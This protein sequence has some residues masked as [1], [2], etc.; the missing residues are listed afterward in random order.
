[1]DAWVPADVV[2]ELR[3]ESAAK[4]LL[5]GS[6]FAPWLGLASAV[7]AVAAAWVLWAPGHLYS[8][9]M[10]WDLLFNLEGAWHLAHGHVP[11]LDFHDPLGRLGFWLTSLG[12][13]VVGVTPK[14]FLVGEFIVL[15][16][17]LAAAVPVAARRLAPAPAL[18]FT[19][20][21][22]LLIV[23]PANIGDAPNAY[24][25]A[26]SYNRWGWAALAILCVLLFIDPRHESEPRW[27]ELLLAAMLGVFLF[28]VKIT[29]AAA[30]LAAVIAAAIVVRRI[31]E[32]WRL[33]M[34]LV[35]VIALAAVLPVNHPY[36]RETWTYATAGYARVNLP[37]IV[38]LVVSDRAAYAL[39]GAAIGLLVWLWQAGRAPLQA[40]LSAVVLVGLGLLVLTQNAQEADIPLG[41]VI[42]LQAYSTLACTRATAIDR[43]ARLAPPSRLMTILIVIL[44][45]PV[46]SVGAAVKVFAGY[47]YSASAPDVMVAP[48]TSNLRGLAVPALDPEVP[49]ALARMGYPLLSTTRVPPLRDPLEQAEYL[50]TL[51]EAAAVLSDR[52]QRVFVMDQV[53]PMPFVLGYPP[54]RGSVLWL[55]PDAPRRS[56]EDTFGDVDVVLV[57]KYSTY[58]PTTALLL[59]IYDEYLR[60]QFPART[61]TPRWTFLRRQGSTATR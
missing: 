36:W 52:S 29:F 8:R 12:F 55:G 20:Y 34:A 58:A 17:L 16:A 2:V 9:E 19:S 30:A 59:D 23:L 47:Y 25:F 42:C 51:L 24:S 40:P 35:G 41:F 27:D 14:A 44:I 31:R 43:G 50:E 61:D 45:W 6:T 28:Y 39:Y 49:N 10:T 33:W 48:A 11:H 3:R 60:R 54:P 38:N 18:L 4:Q 1:M 32:R 5:L 37:Y 15:P 57:P 7:V 13:Q 26:M 53:N 46:L 56:A 21:V 22:A